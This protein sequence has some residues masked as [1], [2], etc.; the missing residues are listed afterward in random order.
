M[1]ATVVAV[2]V[3]VEIFLVVGGCALVLVCVCVCVCCVSVCGCLVCLRVWLCIVRCVCVSGGVCG[4]MLCVEVDPHLRRKG[5][6]HRLIGICGV[7][8]SKPPFQALQALQALLYDSQSFTQ[9]LWALK[10]I[11]SNQEDGAGQHNILA[12]I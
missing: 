2:V 12:Y 8:R 11:L 9:L 1:A 4:C 3:V 6:K 10:F 7:H 5:E